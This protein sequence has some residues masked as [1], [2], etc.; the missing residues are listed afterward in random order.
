MFA[1]KSKKTYRIILNFNR[2]IRLIVI[3]I[4]LTRVRVFVIVA[5]LLH[6]P[7]ILIF[8]EG[9]LL[10]ERARFDWPQEVG[11]IKCDEGLQ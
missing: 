1:Q 6:M 9:H 2:L 5:T 3:K 10:S 7:S 11:K 4:E 8:I